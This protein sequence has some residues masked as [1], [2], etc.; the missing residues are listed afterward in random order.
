MEGGER[1]SKRKGSMQTITWEANNLFKPTEPSLTLNSNLY[2]LL[3]FIH[4]AVFKTYD[5]DRNGS[6]NK[7]EFD[8]LATN[9]PFIDN[10]AVLD[11]NW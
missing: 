5:V 3:F 7:D 11:V 9:F 10:F 6:I 4:Q 1:V 8:Q 2:N